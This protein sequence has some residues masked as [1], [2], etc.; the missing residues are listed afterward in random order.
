MLA[1]MGNGTRLIAYPQANERAG[2]IPFWYCD[3]DPDTTLT[4]HGMCSILH[5]L[6]Y[7]CRYTSYQIN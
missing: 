6:R 5:Y 1:M 2:Q 7:I 3:P 4:L